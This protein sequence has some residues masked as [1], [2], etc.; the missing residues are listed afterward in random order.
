L[1]VVTNVD[2]GHTDPIW[3]VPQGAKLRIDPVAS[4]LTFLET[5]V[6]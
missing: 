4:T 3:T 1:P 5:S 6:T 2:F